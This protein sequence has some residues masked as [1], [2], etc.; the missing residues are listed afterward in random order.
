MKNC[1][2]T[3][4]FLLAMFLVALE[5]PAESQLQWP[6]PPKKA[7]MR[8]RLVALAWADPRSSFFSSHE[9][10]VAETEIGDEEW[11]LIKLVFTFLPYQPRLLYSGFDYSVVH[12]LTAWRDKNCDETISQLTAREGR[13]QR[14]E[15]LIYA[16][17][18]PK[19]NL[20]RRHIPLPCYESTA[21]N[22]SKASHEPIAPPEPPPQPVLKRRWN[23]PDHVRRER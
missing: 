18:V 19:V 4:I 6:E 13:T 10:F 17:D 15:P 20:D 11:S 1:T 7:P 23:L 12:E 14:N 5:K 16:R 22:Y 8:V 21:D 3:A 9:V 2:L